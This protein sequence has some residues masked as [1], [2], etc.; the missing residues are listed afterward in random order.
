MVD[1]GQ[2]ETKTSG[3]PSERSEESITMVA[4]RKHIEDPAGF[5]GCA[6]NDR[7]GILQVKRPNDARRR[8]PNQ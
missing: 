3:C 4:P 8:V 6:Q 5:F 2:V 1:V 7:I